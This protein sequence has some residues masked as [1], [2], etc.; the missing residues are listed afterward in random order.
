MELRCVAGC[1]LRVRASCVLGLYRSMPLSPMSSLSPFSQGPDR[2][3][4]S[5]IVHGVLILAHLHALATFVFGVGL[6][7]ELDLQTDVPTSERQCEGRLL[8]PAREMD[9]RQ[10]QWLESTIQR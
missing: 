1:I 3:S 6:H 8:D 4:P 9:A 7:P 10:R 2:W 5:E